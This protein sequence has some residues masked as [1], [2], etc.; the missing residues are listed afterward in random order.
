[1]ANFSIHD[2]YRRN[3]CGRYDSKA[4]KKNLHAGDI[5]Q[6]TVCGGASGDGMLSEA[7]M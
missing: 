5:E 3:A 6:V 4:R 7:R 2:I 1:M